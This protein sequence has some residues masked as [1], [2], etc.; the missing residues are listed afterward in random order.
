MADFRGF[1]L[2]IL[3]KQ[4]RWVGR[5]ILCIHVARHTSVCAPVDTH[6]EVRIGQQ[7]DSSFTSHLSLICF[8][9]GLPSLPS[10]SLLTPPIFFLSLSSPSLSFLF[11]SPPLST[12]PL[13]PLLSP[14]FPV[15]PLSSLP[16]FLSLPSPP[17]SP[18]PSSPLLSLPLFSSSLPPSLPLPFPPFPL[19]Q[20]LIKQ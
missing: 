7:A 14:S 19:S 17:L 18:L 11:P 10:P 3:Q 1:L 16:F 20:D 6:V 8:C 12:L 13:L 4:S 5:Y 2:N 15:S 9:L